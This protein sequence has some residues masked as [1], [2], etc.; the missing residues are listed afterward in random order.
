MHVGLIKC[1]LRQPVEQSIGNRVVPVF[2]LRQSDLG[3]YAL[4][5]VPCTYGFRHEI[6][7]VS[8]ISWLM[9]RISFIRKRKLWVVNFTVF[10]SQPPVT[11]E[12][13][14][15]H[16]PFHSYACVGRI[17]EKQQLKIALKIA[18]P[19]LTSR[20]EA[21][22]YGG[23]VSSSETQIKCMHRPSR[24]SSYPN[25]CKSRGGNVAFVKMSK[26]N[27]LTRLLSL[28]T[29][30]GD[31]VITAED[32]QMLR[33]GERLLLLLL[34]VEEFFIS[35]R[36][37]TFIRQDVTGSSYTRRTQV[38][39]L[40]GNRKAKEENWA[41][42]DIVEI[43]IWIKWLEF[44]TERSRLNVDTGSSEAQQG[45]Y[46]GKHL[47]KSASDLSTTRRDDR[48]KEGERS[49]LAQT[50]T[51]QA[52]S[53]SNVPQVAHKTHHSFFSTLKFMVS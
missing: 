5:V 12:V 14:S 21:C 41:H 30:V 3:L 20:S 4:I 15:L 25:N 33:T 8:L 16:G 37:E 34:G 10:M 48:D 13:S 50:S 6:T 44:N 51:T 26:N 32:L 19:N 29:S 43:K 18:I 45:G 7:F 9:S 11:S 31:K 46:L 28:I 27:F 24:F 36:N 42:V 17:K 40:S 2:R 39:C 47:S 35:K 23:V 53:T 49:A 22:L 52:Q 1:L 38:M